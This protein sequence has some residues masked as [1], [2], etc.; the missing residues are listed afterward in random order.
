MVWEKI[1]LK[2][3]GHSHDKSLFKRKQKY[4]NKYISEIKLRKSLSHYVNNS[5]A[6]PRRMHS[7]YSIG[8]H[9]SLSEC[10]M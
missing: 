4:K 6:L 2:S 7:G 10:L 8:A 1:H 3:K 9:A 5:N